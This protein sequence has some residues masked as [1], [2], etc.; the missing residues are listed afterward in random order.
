LKKRRATKGNSPEKGLPKMKGEKKQ[1]HYKYPRMVK[2]GGAHLNARGKNPLPRDRKRKKA[3]RGIAS[4]GEKAHSLSKRH[5]SITHTGTLL[6]GGKPRADLGGGFPI[7]GEEATPADGG[8]ENRSDS[9]NIV[10]NYTSGKCAPRGQKQPSDIEVIP[11]KEV[12]LE[13][14]GRSKRVCREKRTS[15]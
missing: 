9:S 8:E 13:K 15:N 5:Q 3:Q 11:S 1:A 2:E 7:T 6:R 4:L 14:K 12:S 10:S